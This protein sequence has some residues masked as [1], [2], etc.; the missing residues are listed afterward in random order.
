MTPELR[1]A[2]D[3]AQHALHHM[4]VALDRLW[5]A[6]SVAVEDQATRVTVR[7]L[8]CELERCAMHEALAEEGQ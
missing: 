7:A 1:R 8:G 2:L 4:Q 6:R 5:V 3:D